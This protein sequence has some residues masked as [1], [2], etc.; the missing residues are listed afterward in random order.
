MKKKILVVDDNRM[1]LKFLENLLS[2]QGHEVMTREDGLSALNLLTSYTPDVMFVDLIIPKIGGDRLCQIVRTMAHMQ[3]CYLVILSGAVM[4]MDLNF[5]QIGVNACIAKGPFGQ[6]GKQVLA[7]VN[8]SDDPLCR[9]STGVIAGDSAADPIPMYARWMTRELAAR[10]R[11]LET[12][13]ESLKE[14]ILEIYTG[15]VVYANTAAVNFFGFSLDRLFSSRFVDLFDKTI[16][17]RLHDLFLPPAGK[18]PI[19][20]LDA[21]FELNCRQLIIRSFPVKGEPETTLLLVTDVTTQRELTYQLQHARR[22]DA[23]GTLSGAMAHH[24]GDLLKGIQKNT[25]ALMQG[26]KPGDPG[27]AELSGIEAGVD[28]ATRLIRQLLRF[29]RGGRCAMARIH[30]KDVIERSADMFARLRKDIQV[31]TRLEE[32]DMWVDADEAQIELALVELYVNAWHAMP[33]GGTLT[34]SATAA[35]LDEKSAAQHHLLPGV[36]QKIDVADNGPGMDDTTLERMFD[37]FYAARPPENGTGVGLASVLSLVREHKGAITVESRMGTG[38]TVSVYLPEAGSA[39][40]KGGS[41]TEV[42]PGA[43][44]PAAPKKDAGTVLVVDDEDYILMADKAMLMELGYEVLLAG[45]GKEGIAV[46]DANKDRIVLVIVDLIMP[47]LGGE[48]VCRHI[49]SVSPETR[50]LL[51]SGYI[52]EGEAG[53]ALKESGDGFLQKPYNLAQFA[54]KIKAVLGV[55]K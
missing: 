44:P 3:Q 43:P 46:F 31:V 23:I 25:A 34:I 15:R 6:M 4:E 1:I 10:N 30:I 42:L 20:G 7:A 50:V 18:T 28:S 37:P 41:G 29:S 17:R 47:D 12:L 39:E 55:E 53:R 40:K 11:H 26:K 35:T 16:R 49:K 13:L 19:L 38:T 45:G 5:E 51:C 22:M 14:G 33:G 32:A 21:P 52:I 8:D 36:Y 27:Y 48:A 24:F 54:E 2:A 9:F